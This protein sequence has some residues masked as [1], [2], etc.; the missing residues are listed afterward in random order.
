MLKCI[1]VI[2]E[3]GYKMNIYDKT[4]AIISILI[5]TFI[6]FCVSVGLGALLCY[7]LNDVIFD[8]KIDTVDAIISVCF[9]LFV[10]WKICPEDTKN[11]IKNW[12]KPQ[13][14][15]KKN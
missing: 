9:G 15:D 7:V 8:H 4:I 2:V 5:K 3:R 14:T 10:F 1:V 11:W 12:T 13:L 6:S